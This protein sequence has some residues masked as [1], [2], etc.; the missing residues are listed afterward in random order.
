MML[1]AT[2]TVS[3]T[4]LAGA[5][6]AQ[7]T[8]SISV[9]PTEAVEDFKPNPPENFTG[10]V[11]LGGTF[12]TAAPGRVGGGTVV[13]AP[14]ARTNWHSH[15]AGQ[16]LIVIDGA[17]FVQASDG[18]RQEIKR[19]DI[20][21]IPAGVKHWHGAQADRAMTHIAIAEVVDGAAATWM[22]PVTDTQYGG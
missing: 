7:D 21:T 5:A 11:R 17:G 19:G 14:G 4:L 10:D 20:V 9:V 6:L 12:K 1:I 13:F 8:P 15:P 16:T 2:T 22:E 3:A 18:P